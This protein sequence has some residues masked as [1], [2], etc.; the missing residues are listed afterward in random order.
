MHIRASIRFLIVA[1]HME[2]FYASDGVSGARR[3]SPASPISPRP[4]SE[5]KHQA[6]RGSGRSSSSS[7]TKPFSN[8]G[9][10]SPP[11]GPL[12]G[13][14]CLPTKS[15]MIPSSSSEQRKGSPAISAPPLSS[16]NQQLNTSS[17]ILRATP[18]RGGSNGSYQTNSGSPGAALE[19]LEQ[20]M[21]AQ[22]DVEGVRD[23]GVELGK[24]VSSRNELDSKMIAVKAEK[25]VTLLQ[26]S[27]IEAA[28]LR[29]KDFREAAATAERQLAAEK[30]GR[31]DCVEMYERQ[32]DELKKRLVV[33]ETEKA[34][35]IAARQA[36]EKEAEEARASADS[37][38]MDAAGS[39]AALEE[40]NNMQ[41]P[42]F[43]P[44]G[45][46][47]APDMA[48]A[49]PASMAESRAGPSRGMLAPP[50]FAPPGFPPLSQ[51]QENAG[52]GPGPGPHMGRISQD[53]GQPPPFFS[54]HPGDMQQPP[55]M[56]GPVGH[57]PPPGMFPPPGM[58]PPPPSFGGPL[59]FGVF[60]NQMQQHLDH[61]RQQQQG[62]GSPPQHPQGSH[63]M[64][65]PRQQARQQHGLLQPSSEDMNP[66]KEV[67]SHRGGL[68]PHTEVA[69]QDQHSTLSSLDSVL[70]GVGQPGA[71][72]AGGYHP[73][74]SVGGG[75]FQLD[76][77]ARAPG[78][79]LKTG[80]PS[81]G[82]GGASA[83]PPQPH[84][85]LGGPTPGEP[86]RDPTVSPAPH[87]AAPQDFAN[88]ARYSGSVVLTPMAPPGTQHPT[89]IT[90][91]SNAAAAA[92]T[93]NKAH[94][95][96][97]NS[98][99]NLGAAASSHS[100]QAE[101]QAPASS[102]SSGSAQGPTVADSNGGNGSKQQWRKPGS[103]SGSGSKA[104]G[105][106]TPGPQS[107]DPPHTQPQANGGPPAYSHGAP[108]VQSKAQGLQQQQ[109][110]SGPGSKAVGQA[111]A[112][113][114]S[115][116]ALKSSALK[117]VGKGAGNAAVPTQQQQRINNGDKGRQAQ[118]QGK[119]S[120][121]DEK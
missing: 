75:Y 18:T 4:T 8:T 50:G 54:V 49:P 25:E 80:A 78:S 84:L 100:G 7:S 119:S 45:G 93:N 121:G 46:P 101:V 73:S 64:M 56:N 16:L 87:S 99:N 55:M 74:I 116:A 10:S 22:A 108:K 27:S 72:Q 12:L 48:Y 82:L 117:A 31:A 57:G 26:V 20:S 111:Q 2:L 41:H 62:Q 109:Q 79:P 63:G 67:S 106:A 113:S 120:G 34:G 90:H 104:Y 103:V 9:T 59:S 88:S 17:L 5:Y 47:G 76:G 37:V 42:P 52:I 97:S 102:A 43:L 13:P 81:A 60:M 51:M 3:D 65:D 105:A 107:S 86:T 70:P 66:P 58:G 11:T 33:A 77:Q 32:V 40:S 110:Q 69:G 85:G 92:S 53:D 29:Q 39:A 44:V 21:L 19:K 23:L 1:I 91:L 96:S 114:T 89:F 112:Q 35:A 30:Q 118:L 95:D 38:R 36:L 68:G 61:S 24:I 15:D 28:A 98:S 14:S 94:S 115:S 71:F 83:A 6:S